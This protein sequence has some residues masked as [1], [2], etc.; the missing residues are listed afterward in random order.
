[1]KK[2]SHRELAFSFYSVTFGFWIQVSK[3]FKLCGFRYCQKSVCNLLMKASGWRCEKIHASQSI[4]P[5]DLCLVSLQ[6]LSFFTVGL[7]GHCIIPSQTLQKKCFQSAESKGSPRRA[8]CTQRKAFLQVACFWFSSWD[9]QNSMS[10]RMSLPRLSKKRFQS[11]ESN[12]RLKS[13]SWIHTL[14]NVLKDSFFLVF[15]KGYSVLY[16]RPSWSPKCPFHDST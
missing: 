11:A 13:V 5:D 7:N 10:S 9:S 14:Q 1:M 4:F 6:D 3:G 8:E 16:H 15:I 2:Q 12:R